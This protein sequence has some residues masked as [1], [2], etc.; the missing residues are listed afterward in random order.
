M[1]KLL[2]MRSDLEY[3]VSQLQ[4][5]VKDLQN[6]IREIDKAII[7][8]GFR[9]SSSDFQTV[10]LTETKSKDKLEGTEQITTQI[11]KNEDEASQSIQSKDGTVLGQIT[12][13]EDSITFIPREGFNFLT[14]TPPFQSF[15]I[16]RVLHN[17]MITDEQKAKAD[18]L[19]PTQ[20]L[21]YTIDTEGDTIKKVIVRNF[22]GERRLR[23]IQS[24]FRW[25]FDKMYD[26]SKRG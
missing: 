19:D 9:Q 24:S 21:N 2:S 12:T 22:G 16:E 5:E 4:F 13:T 1:K 10:K 7:Q 20:I 25:S 14:S 18:E 11:I 17:M 23:E 26:K 8:Q 15:L 3:R 6:A